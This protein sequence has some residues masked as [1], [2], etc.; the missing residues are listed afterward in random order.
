MARIHRR[1][2]LKWSI[3]PVICGITNGLCDAS[4]ERSIEVNIHFF[5]LNH[6]WPGVCTRV[7]AYGRGDLPFDPD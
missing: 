7:C 5:V 4:V 1:T 6:V 2:L 3:S